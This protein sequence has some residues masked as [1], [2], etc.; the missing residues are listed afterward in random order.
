MGCIMAEMVR[1]KILFPG[2]DC[3]LELFA[4]VSGSCYE[5]EHGTQASK[6]FLHQLASHR[7]VSCYLSD[8]SSCSHTPAFFSS[9]CIK[10]T[11]LAHLNSRAVAPIITQRLNL[12]RFLPVA[13]NKTFYYCSCAETLQATKCHLHAVHLCRTHH[14]MISFF[15]FFLLFL[16]FDGVF[17]CS[18]HQFLLFPPALHANW[19]VVISFFS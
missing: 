13:K 14:H 15:F 18:L 9:R 8:T 16:S 3:I 10:L 4:A 1:H 5:T 7:P 2:R 11:Q 6:R 12:I 19:V 17:S